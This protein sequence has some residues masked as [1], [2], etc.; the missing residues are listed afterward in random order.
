MTNAERLSWIA[1]ALLATALVLISITPTQAIP[2]PPAGCGNWCAETNMTRTCTPNVEKL[3]T[4]FANRT[5]HECPGDGSANC[6]QFNFKGGRCKIVM[7]N[8]MAWPGAYTVICPCVM[9]NNFADTF[10]CGKDPLLPLADIPWKLCD[11]NA[12]EPE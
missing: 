9:F 6:H 3:C 5:C 1:S 12:T 8:Q 7:P 4:E 11:P 2:A 10:T